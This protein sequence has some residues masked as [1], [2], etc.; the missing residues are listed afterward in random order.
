M[1]IDVKMT[2]TSSA[3]VLEFGQHWGDKACQQRG[4]I[5]LRNQ[6]HGESFDFG[7]ISIIGGMRFK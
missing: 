1:K 5:I 3:L 6:S 4:I 7:P 2:L